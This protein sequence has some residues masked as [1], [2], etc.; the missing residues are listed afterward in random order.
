[1]S[2]LRFDVK[3][4]IIITLLA[5]LSVTSS[6]ANAEP[7]D[8]SGATTSAIENNPGLHAALLDLHRA[9]RAVDAEEDLYPLTLQLDAGVTHFRNP[10]L[11]QTGGVTTTTADQIVMGSELRKLFPFGTSMALRVEGNWSQSSFQLFPGSS[12]ELT[13]GPGYGLSARFTMV[14]PLL[15]GFGTD[16]GEVALRSAKIDRSGA[17][18]TRDRAASEL[19]RDALVAYWNLW[20]ASEALRIENAARD[21]AKQELDETQARIDGD[22][23]A[24]VEIY[25]FSARVSEL[26][27][28]VLLA[29]QERRRRAVELGLHI[30]RP[31]HQSRE[32]IADQAAP[33]GNPPLARK[34]AIEQALANAPELVEADTNIARAREAERSAGEP[35]RHRL[36]ITGWVETQGLGNEEVPP[37]L[38][39][40][41]TF[42]A[43]SAHVGLVWEM[44]LTGS[45]RSTQKDRA[46]LGTEANIERREA[47]RQSI[48]TNTTLLLDQ[49]EMADE[50]SAIAQKTQELAAKQLDAA[51]AKYDG[52]AGLAIEIQRAEESI[53]R[54]QLRE[55]RARVDSIIANLSLRHLTGDMLAQYAPLLARI[56]KNRKPRQ[57]GMLGQRGPF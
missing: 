45:R 15:R 7:I 16:A 22:A 40:F 1:M 44:P 28:A 19:L 6:S 46:R 23:L 20:F 43:F 50:R 56:G 8:E 33:L 36:D 49:A 2:Y 5:V 21:L 48:E 27:E 11:Q 9:G 41:G 10:R 26:D 13:L 35:D 32:L 17:A 47:L 54:A 29:E 18:S 30:G 51:K 37:A 14:Q 4:S 53:R 12:Q 24:P 25:P 55:A 39:Q 31:G 52:G 3:R 38:E 34:A 57:I 42:G